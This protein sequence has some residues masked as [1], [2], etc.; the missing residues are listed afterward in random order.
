[1]DW[2][3]AVDQE[4]LRE[5][6]CLCTWKS[7]EYHWILGSIQVRYDAMADD[8]GKVNGNDTGNDD[9]EVKATVDVEE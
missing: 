5:L 3:N 9:Q 2:A 1:M 6:D 4:E 7:C 8:N